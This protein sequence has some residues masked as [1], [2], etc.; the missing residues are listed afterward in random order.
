MARFPARGSARPPACPGHERRRPGGRRHR[1]G[2]EAVR[3]RHPRRGAFQRAQCRLQLVGD[4]GQRGR[5]FARLEPAGRQQ[6]R[7][8]GRPAARAALVG[9]A[10]GG[11]RAAPRLQLPAAG[12]MGQPQVPGH[13]RAGAAPR[14]HR[15]ADVRCRRLPQGGLCLS[16]GAHPGRDLRRGAAVEQRRRRPHLA[17]ERRR[18]PRHHP[19]LRRPHRRAAL[20]RRAP[21]RQRHRRPVA[22]H[23]ARR[24]ERARLLHHHAPDDHPVPRAVRRHARLRRTR[25]G[26]SPTAW[27]WSASAPLPP[28]SA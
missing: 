24:P 15:A 21:A 3:L 27:P 6:A 12:R 26:R 11:E 5:P 9:G 16:L 23:R 2:L 17:L 25:G 4:E 8:P 18:R 28:A 13:A 10:A 7:A 22:D 14:P 19:G 1:A 20:R